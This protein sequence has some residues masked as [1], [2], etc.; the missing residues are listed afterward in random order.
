M[1]N[2]DKSL[3]NY[4][5][6]NRFLSS[7]FGFRNM[8][9]FRK[10]LRDKSEGINNNGIHHFTEILKNLDI[11][12]SFRQKLDVYDEHIQEYLIHINQQRDPSIALKYFQYVAILLTEIHL[13]NY[14]NNFD[15]YYDTLLKFINKINEEEDKSRGNEYP[16]PTQKNLRK[17]AFWSAT[18]SGK[19]IIMHINYLQILKYL[20]QSPKDEF[21]NILL[22][23]P[24][25]GLSAQHMDELEKSS[26]K[27]DKFEID[28][29][30]EDLFYTNQMKVIE[31]TKIRD[32]DEVSGEGE[33]VPV[34][35][36]GK[37]NLLFVDE[38]HKGTSTKAKIWK[39]HRDRLVENNGFTFEYS[40]TFGEVAANAET[41]NEY[42]NSIVFDYRYKFFYEDGFGKDYEILNLKNKN[43]YGD[44]YF[45]GAL[46]SFYEQKLYFNNYQNEIGPFNL[47]NPLMIF[48]G[49]RV[50][51]G[52]KSSDVYEVINL[53]ARFINEEEKFDKFVKK[54][55]RNES[56]LVDENSSP[57]FISKFG[58]L[59]S[60]IRGDELSI[61]D[62]YSDMKRKLFHVHTSRKM[63]LRQ[64]TE[65]EGE[66]G[67]K[68][69]NR[70]FGLINI[71]DPDKFIKYVNRKN[72][73]GYYQTD[74]KANL[75]GSLFRKIEKAASPLNFLI[76][77]RKF[78]EGWDSYRV[79][80]MGLL[81]I[82]KS[83]G[84]QIIQLFGRGVRLKGYDKMLKRSYV[85][86]REGSLPSD[87]DIPDKM[88]LLE[89]LNIFGL[90]ANYME[91]F[92]ENLKEEGI[93]EYEKITLRVKPTV[94]EGLYV[95]RKSGQAGY[96][97]DKVFLE[98]LNTDIR[99][100]KLDFS[101][102]ID[103]LESGREKLR[104][105]HANSP[106]SENRF[107]DEVL[108]LLDFQSI[109]LELL[110]YKDLKK[111]DNLYFTK[112][113]LKELLQADDY[114][115]LCNEELLQIKEDE[116]F[117]KL[118]KIENFALQT[119]KSIIDKKYKTESAHWYQGN[120]N[121][122]TVS[123][124][125][126]ALIPKQY[127]FTINTSANSFI[128][129]VKELIKELRGYVEE[130]TEEETK[131]YSEDNVFKFQDQ[132]IIKFFSLNIHLFQPLLYK[133][134]INDELDF[135]KISPL[136][137]VK[138]ERDFIKLLKDYV[139]KESLFDNIYLLRNPSRKGIGFFKT[140]GFYPDFILWT[141]KGDKQS[142]AFI[143]PKGLQ[144]VKK[145]DE[146]LEL[147]KDIKDIESQLKGKTGLDISLFSFIF[148]RTNYSDLSWDM[149][150][151]DLNDKNILFLEDGEEA[152]E[153]IF[154]RMDSQ[155]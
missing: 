150:K 125:D 59:K 15:A 4:L 80:N 48:V 146:K 124:D 154:D 98:N 153:K 97:K 70:Y 18:G 100:I 7:F 81:N 5:V 90:N 89:T 11:N 115:I 86:D 94:K 19:T 127:I 92:R 72:E 83:A 9:D 37:K 16:Y 2:T 39:S 33:S 118:A 41:F 102:K 17:L 51:G 131:L 21:D 120:L 49:S 145:D 75:Q 138:S 23:T 148:S 130:K 73:S 31:I 6:L 64:L 43:N 54:I 112:D 139:D 55:L 77:S 136:D 114:N 82:G 140:K 50:Q 71:G 155:S 85:L 116:S 12:N 143:D 135:I 68:F 123:E 38:G 52:E 101:P 53:M 29:S 26:I 132:E 30:S 13:D 122:Q 1:A 151:E 67:L 129:D 60:L 32:E 126:R 111:Y 69:D 144:R 99:A 104:L 119:L 121:Y 87:V 35:A 142:I 133:N 105:S 147:Y 57:I 106:L 61:E 117:A 58:Y 14:F 25:S 56:S 110:K 66:I 137:L 108:D 84:S 8:E 113:E 91:R 128:D 76:G 46:L 141:I 149:S 109:Y 62:I 47:K 45:T 27:H 103:V 74:L 20:G 10:E 44:E 63:E 40:A 3:K 134:S 42:A 88:N 65:A 22:I 28:N 34:Q 107:S 95:P 96:F 93:E 79:S 78:I 36:F 152:L 24:N